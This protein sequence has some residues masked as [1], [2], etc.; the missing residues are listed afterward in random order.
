MSQTDDIKQKLDIADLIGEYITLKPAGSAAFKASCPFHK[1]KT[2]SFHVSR[3]RQIWHC[4][5]CN[6]GGDHFAFVMKMEGVDFPEALRQL[7]EKTGVEIKR[8][9]SESANAKGRMLEV[10]DL[11]AR[12]YHKLFL[13][14]ETAALAR[15]YIDKRGISAEAREIFQLGYSPDRWDG[16]LTVLKK[17]GYRDQELIGAGL[18]IRRQDSTGAYDRFRH[19]VMF[20][21]FDVRGKV[22]GFAARLLDEKREEGKYINTPETPAYHK[23][24]ILYGL[25]LA[26]QAIKEAGAVVIVEGNID[27][28]ASHEAGVKNVV[29]SSGTALTVEQITILK[30]F[31]DTLLVC[32]DADPAGEHA[33]K[34]GIDLALEAGMNVRVIQ[35]VGAKD[36]DELVRRDPKA[37]P[38]AIA[39]ATDVM[40]YYFNRVFISGNPKLAADKKQ[41]GN[42]LLPEIRRLPNAI[43]RSHWLHEL[44][45]HLGV[46]EEVLREAMAGLP[47]SKQPKQTTAEAARKPVVI[48]DRRVKLAEAFM[49]MLFAR[50]DIRSEAITK[51]RGEDIP[52]PYQALYL[53]FVTRYHVANEP[54]A[55]VQETALFAQLRAELEGSSPELLPLFDRLTIE[56]ERSFAA[57][58]RPEILTELERIAAGLASLA[59]RDARELIARDL[60][61][62]ELAGDTSRVNELTKKFKETV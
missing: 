62:A 8:F 16:L 54:P 13:D 57:P 51:A 34:R 43:E 2:P 45:T 36:P 5:G 29:A 46:G 11:A 42:V 25:H 40:T 22:V 47:V 9:V 20:P 26:K 6:E 23:G 52:T 15:A 3:E 44:S 27:V 49:A 55:T 28:I 56:G 41:A 17:R 31:T 24:Q 14:G 53:A 37:W 30:R 38:A 21:I 33:A 60:R 61:D 18:A 50:P 35:L 4:F 7:A 10:L 1:E 48:T 59:V 58:S 12:F 19:R 39:E 32:F